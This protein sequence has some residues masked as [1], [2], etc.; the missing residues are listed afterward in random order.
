MKNVYLTLSV[1][2]LS[3]VGTLEAQTINWEKQ[4]ITERSATLQ[5]FGTNDDES[6]ATIIGYSN[7]IY[8]ST[9]GGDSWVESGLIKD[10]D[11]FD[12]GTL[13]IVGNFGITGDYNTFKV[14]DKPS[15]GNP[16]LMAMGNILMTTDGGE[17]WEQLT[18]DS[19][20]DSEDDA[21]NLNAIG[22]YYV[23]I[24]T[25]KVI[26]DSTAYIAAT[27][28]DVNGTKHG[29]IFKTTNTGENWSAVTDDFGSVSIGSIVEHNGDIYVGGY[30][31]LF[32]VNTLTDSVSN[33]YDKVAALNKDDNMFFVNIS[34]YNDEVFFPTYSDSIWV[35]SDGGES[36]STIAPKG[37]K[38]AYYV[39]KANDSVIVTTGSSSTTF[40][41]V[42]GGAT[43][44]D[45]YPGASLWNTVVI[46]DSLVGLATDVIY[47]MATEDIANGVF[48]WNARSID[49][50]S[51]QY[52]G[53]AINDAGDIFITGSNDVFLVSKD[54]G[55]TFSDVELPSKSDMVLASLDLKL[56][57]Y[58]QRG[59]YA[60][61]TSRYYTLADYPS[62]SDNIDYNVPGVI[63]VTEDSWASAYVIDD[64][65]IGEQ[66]G[67]DV[68]ANP[69]A[70][71]CLNQDY[72]AAGIADDS[73]I[74]VYVAWQ[75]TAGVDYS[76]R[77]KHARVFKSSNAIANAKDDD[78]EVVW[79]TI[80]PDLGSNYVKRIDIKG[81]KGYIYGNKTLYYTQNGG[82]SLV[83]LKANLDPDEELKPY[84]SD[85]REYDGKIFVATSADSVWVSEDNGTT[86][87]T[88]SDAK[89]AT[90]GILILNDSSWMTFG[91][92]SYAKYTVDAGNTW[93]SCYPG[94]SVYS[95][96]G[97]YNGNIIAL[98]KSA[99]YKQSAADIDPDY[100]VTAINEITNENLSK[101][102]FA[103]SSQSLS[104]TSDVNISKCELYN[105]AGQRV[106]LATPYST[107]YTIST[108]QYP[109]GIYLIKVEAEDMV[110]KKIII[111]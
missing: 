60:I 27:W 13:S 35:T 111:Q 8:Q 12:Y 49:D 98:Y 52:K 3:L 75:D 62:S 70:G 41:T 102:S 59:D 77:V 50:K 34:T 21:L 48:N 40:A 43:W 106:M 47:T 110:T 26:N 30:Q 109:S 51:A 68:S 15:K 2:L 66:Y 72:F 19:I 108:S 94:T 46:G 24:R 65:K 5:A 45:I 84:I 67:E 101:I 105:I 16:D 76:D 83:D 6:I 36:F 96:G 55:K 87:Y 11:N 10:A 58:G 73:T 42:D 104:I 82:Y 37:P 61:M 14:V 97:V 89:G 95:H 107:N 28:Y 44:T 100:E 79:D 91:S 99:I 103:Q 56:V 23:Q 4:T 86:F 81:D 92:E 93:E 85:V 71:T 64:S 1:I 32:K 54:G 29:N 80:T 17:T 22:N 31:H 33:L 38:G 18:V 90:A 9:D 39:Y 69:F 74:Y 63:W 53:M 57:G 25:S 78:I 88:I 7:T 20:G